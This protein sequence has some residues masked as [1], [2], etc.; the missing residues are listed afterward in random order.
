MRTQTRAAQVAKLIRKDLKE[1]FPNIKFSVRSED[2]TDGDSVD[3]EWL[4]S[5][6]REVIDTFLKKYEH[7][8]RYDNCIKGLLQVKY[9]DCSRRVSSSFYENVFKIVKEQ[10]FWDCVDFN[11]KGMECGRVPSIEVQFLLREKYLG[12][13]EEEALSLAIKYFENNEF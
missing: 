4:W 12:N 6:Q 9:I 5:E 10:W 13:N 7:G 1:S 2:F 11:S 3:I 8:F